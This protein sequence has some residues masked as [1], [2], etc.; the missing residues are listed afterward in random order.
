M[1]MMVRRKRTMMNLMK[2][3]LARADK[4]SFLH[5][6]MRSN[7]KQIIIATVELAGQL[8]PILISACVILPHLNPLQKISAEKLMN[9]PLEMMVL[10]L[11]KIQW[12]AIWTIIMKRKVRV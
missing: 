11:R 1:M 7:M 5:L 9:M 12:Q 6:K 3:G 4:D 2:N 10:H 8:V